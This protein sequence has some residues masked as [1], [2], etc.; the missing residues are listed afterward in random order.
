MTKALINLLPHES[1]KLIAVGITA[2]DW[3]REKMK[4]GRIFVSRGTTNAY[5]L[6]E[7]MAIREFDKSCYV[8]GQIIPKGER[9]NVCPKEKR[10]KEILFTDG[11]PGEVNSFKDVMDD[12]KKGDI[13][14][15]GANALDPDGIAGV[16]LADLKAGTC[17]LFWGTV[18]AKGLTMLIPVGLEKLVA[19]SVLYSSMEMGIEEIDYADGYK[20]GLFPLFGDVFTEIDALFTLF[21]LDD[22]VHVSSG[23]VGGAEG[24]IT[25]LLIG[26][27]DIIKK[28]YDFCQKL[29]TIK[30][31]KP[32]T[33]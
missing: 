3:V 30:P 2:L 23:G 28:A 6:E 26:E 7:M 19:H 13:V 1:K 18:K 12:M 15:K 20:S 22:V 8:A 31:F 24:S 25:L 29:K 9:L 17:G 33:K 32:T 27:E 4:K 5:V 21:D 14:I 16:L 10:L 11:K